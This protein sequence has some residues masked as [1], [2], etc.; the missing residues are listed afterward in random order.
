MKKHIFSIIYMFLITLVFTSMVSA[1]KY[2]HNQRI[3]SNE[4][5]KLQGIILKVLNIPLNKHASNQ[6]MIKI[7]EN[8]IKETTINGKRIFIGYDQNNE[9]IKGYAFPVS[10]PGFWGPIFG[11]AAVDE[12]AEKLIGL[13]F[14]RHSETP[15]LGGR[16]TEKWFQDQFIG[17][18]LKNIDKNDH[19][20][21]LRPEGTKKEPYEL[22]AITGATMTSRGVEKFLN[23][24]LED[25]IS[26]IRSKL[27][28]TEKSSLSQRAQ[29]HRVK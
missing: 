20:F 11:L 26:S 1:V 27:I 5:V 9:T 24:E 7:F 2:F 13:A 12:K 16:I 10:G 22:D 6:E 18:R 14:Y 8:H 17:L 3:E 23:T 15:G 25:F 28:I 19:I 29:S 21:Y 4:K